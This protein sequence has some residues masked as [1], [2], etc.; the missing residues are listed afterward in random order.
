MSSKKSNG[1]ITLTTD[2]GDRDGYVSVMKGVILSINPRVRLVDISH[3]VA[4]QHIDTAAFIVHRSYRYFPAGTIHVIVVDPEVGSERKILAV[5]AGGHFFIAPDNQVLKYI[6]FEHETSTVI[7]VLNKKYFLENIS[8][9]FHGRDIFAP[10]AAHLSLGIPINKFG[11]ITQN[12]QRATINAPIISA[13]QITG[14]IIYID[15]FGN[16]ITNIRHEEVAGKQFSVSCG[17]VTINQLSTCYAE[18]EPGTALILIDSFGMLE[19]AVR[20]G[21]AQQTLNI[22]MNDPVTLDLK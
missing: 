2:F 21:N 3:A 15:R 6:F 22:Q 10:V 11:S 16:C 18:V 17:N 13:N 14:T 7:E 12:F 4:A 5:F 8:T 1:I 9:T 20:N 19:I